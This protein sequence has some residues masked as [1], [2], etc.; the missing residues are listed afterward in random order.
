MVMP[1]AETR[2]RRLWS[3]LLVVG[4]TVFALLAAELILAVTERNP[5]R[6][7]HRGFYEHDPLLGWKKKPNARR[8][9]VTE[10]FQA[11]ESTNS[12]GIR[13]SEYSCEKDPNE[14]RLIVLG[15]SYSEGYTVDFDELFS[16]VLKRKLNEESDGT[17][18]E[19]INTGTVGY[20]T[21]QELL[22]Y[23]TLGRKYN[24]D[25]VL[26]MFYQNDPAD[27]S[28]KGEICGQYKRLFRV[29]GNR[30]VLAKSLD[31]GAVASDA[32]V[33]LEH[34][35]IQEWLTRSSRVFRLI[36]S[37][38][39][40]WGLKEK[41]S[42]RQRKIPYA[43]HFFS[44]QA[45]LEISQAWKTTERLILELKN[46]VEDSGA[47][48][49]VCYIP[50]PGELDADSWEATKRTYGMTG[51]QWNVGQ[52]EAELRRICDKN[53][54]VC[55]GG[56]RQFEQGAGSVGKKAGSLYHR[57]DGHWNSEGHRIAG[58][59]LATHVRS[60]SADKDSMFSLRHASGTDS[61][62]IQET[63]PAR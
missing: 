60:W 38:L 34:F 42:P 56:V 53:S 51:D 30:L 11:V 40:G 22:L 43:L 20:G 17:H 19:V 45:S 32:D 23:Q 21:D 2:G 25:L 47:R 55:I 49:L 63:C 3:T 8:V 31:P 39:E 50:S 59:M 44:K 28:S 52:I 37:R 58:E 27:N 57:K 6:V 29:E 26:L 12:Q 15:D 1:R 5:V 36:E 41:H 7:D 18:Y 4:S 46:I 33:E 61:P 13:G 35:D 14:Y 9:N 48:L 16:E 62:R 10:E 54:I 24:P